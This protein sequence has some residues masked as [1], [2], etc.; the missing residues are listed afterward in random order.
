M[1][2]N[3]YTKKRS[4]A[5][6]VLSRCIR[7]KAASFLK[8]CLLLSLLFV[9]LAPSNAQRASNS[10]FGTDFWVSYLYFSYSDYGL[11]YT[12]S[13]KAFVV[14]RRAC[15]VTFS[16]PNT[17][18]SRVTH[19]VPGSV[20]LVD[21]DYDAACT[22]TSGVVSETAIHVT[23]TDS[24][25]L[26]ILNLGHNSLDITNA[27][28][29]PILRSSYM[30]QCYQ[31]KLT[32]DYRSEVVVVATEDSTVVDIV[33]HG[34]T[35]N[36]F[37]PG[38]TQTVTLQQGQAYQL[39]GSQTGSGDLTGT[40][41]T[42]RDGKKLAV[43]SG[44]FCAYVRPEC[45][46]CDHIFDQS[47][48]I[49]YWG[50]K[51]SLRG[52]ESMVEDRI[53][54]M[55]MEDSC[56]VTFYGSGGPRN[57]VTLDSAGDWFEGSLDHYGWDCYVESSAPISLC[58]FMG[59][60]GNGQGDPSLIN[61]PPID[62][63]VTE[64]IFA[65]YST[66]Y[67]NTHFV[68]IMAKASEMPLIRLDGNPITSHPN[69]TNTEY[70]YAR[71]P[72]AAGQHALTTSGEGF[73]AYAYGVGSHES[74][75]Y[76]VGMSLAAAWQTLLVNGHTVDSGAVVDVCYPDT[77][78]L[79][80]SSIGEVDSVLWYRDRLFKGRGMAYM[81]D[82][83]PVGT[84]QFSA[85][86][87]RTNPDTGEP[88]CVV[89]STTIRVNPSYERYDSDTI[90]PSQLPWQYAGCLFHEEGYRP[91]RLTTQEGCDSLIHY[92]LVVLD[93]VDVDLFDTLC[94]GYPYQGYG[95]SLSADEVGA[96]GP[97]VRT[98]DT[99]R[100]HLHLAL[101]SQPSLA[102]RTEASGLGYLLQAVTDAP[103]V[104]WHSSADPSFSSTAS[105]IYAEALDAPV[106][107]HARAYYSKGEDC[108]TMD[109]VRLLPGNPDC[110]WAPN[111]ITPDLPTN[112]QFLLTLCNVE[113][114]ELSIF[115][116]WGNMIFHTTDPMQAW[117]ASSFKQGTYVWIAHYTF[118]DSPSER[119]ESKGT[120]T[121]VR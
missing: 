12:V 103:N 30:V 88:Y 63:T 120:V 4:C 105:T 80:V 118:S 35:M 78:T 97:F 27:L 61:I 111:V 24:I 51:F 96:G 68:N 117:D 91:I 37:R 71:V 16:N 20:S 112:S 73:V 39:R 98:E 82:S 119:K 23:A 85:R 72:I 52:T 90:A 64:A 107:Y 58:L 42:A 46:S 55:S 22:N 104:V 18:F 26:Y 109:S 79:S 25:I 41:I 1:K 34:H 45:T 60:T 38:V 67:T 54:V 6:D 59:S 32:T 44:H 74:Y 10:S 81:I 95:F 49:E 93:T 19:V 13:L 56:V 77:V 3:S 43:Y 110:L 11:S 62:H 47:L 36:G 70:A 29:T 75:G 15:D 57:V 86:I 106:V 101:L 99:I 31:S 65:T 53:K 28:P 66:P 2:S 83:L 113:D 8:G 76:A 9:S 17:G 114:F 89:L 40:R 108:S 48:P 5:A 100:Y 121:V 7:R 84:Y 102:I 116:R 87:Y 94:M 115:D 50:R 92:T 14:A 33:P 21:I 69:S